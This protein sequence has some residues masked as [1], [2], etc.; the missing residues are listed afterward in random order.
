MAS[1][2]RGGRTKR[3]DCHDGR[4][5]KQYHFRR[6]A[7]GA[8]DAWDV[9]RLVALAATR[10]VEQV[11]LDSIPDVDRTY[12]YDHGYEPTVRSVVEHFRLM[13]QADLSYPIV[14]DPEGGVM[15][16]M[17]RVARALAESRSTIAARRLPAMPE[18]DFRDCHPEDLPYE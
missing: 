15:D 18:P 4:V 16:G 12:W 2:R 14:I 6:G 3:P 7:N 13:M 1:P 11:P 9:D 8:L 17:H 5:R 10:P